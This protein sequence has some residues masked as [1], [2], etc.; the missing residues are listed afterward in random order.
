V[1]VSQPDAGQSATVGRRPL[2]RL[3]DWVVCGAVVAGSITMAAAT[4]RHAAAPQYDLA[5][6][7]VA[8]GCGA[9]VLAIVGAVAV[10]TARGAMSGLLSALATLLFL[11]GLLA[12]L[13]IGLLLLAGALPVGRAVA[14]RTRGT[15]TNARPIIGGMAMAV[16]LVVALFVSMRPP[17]VACSPGGATTSGGSG[18]SM[19]GGID[20]SV[21]GTIVSGNHEY[22]F[23][24]SGGRLTTFTKN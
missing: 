18:S 22:R 7:A 2:V 11:T 23:T 14:R 6:V 9:A 24:C 3:F 21:S 15:T 5:A 16:G 17:L 12:I 13:S 19:Q 20:G 1:T 8:V 4:I 10:A